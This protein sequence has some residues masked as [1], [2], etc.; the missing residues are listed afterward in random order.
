MPMDKIK[1]NK[2]IRSKRK[3][4]ALI[5]TSDAEL[6]IRAPI[7][8]PLQY[9][10]DLVNK[11]T[12]WIR[13]KLNEIQKNPKLRTKEFINGESFLYLGEVYKLIIVNNA[14][15]DIKIKD[16]YIIIS[17]SI[18]MNVKDVLIKWY[19]AE[20]KKKIKERCDIYS[21]ITGYRPNSVKITNAQKR[22]GSCSSKGTINFSWRLIM[23]TEDVIDYVIV[24]ELVHLKQRDHSRLFWN[25]V[26]DTLPDYKIRQKWL[27]DNGRYLNI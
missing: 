3:T 9:L 13:A 26:K 19:K 4:V 14:K 2:I 21:K 10:K 11:K 27:K 12:Q 22:W 25:K 18:A 15:E 7:K 23:A 6:I 24:H 8:T 1:I 5:V 20:A 17:A 16:N